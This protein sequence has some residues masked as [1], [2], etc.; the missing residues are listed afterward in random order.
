MEPWRSKALELL[1]ELTSTILDEDYVDHPMQL[2]IEITFEFDRAYEEPRNEDLIRRIYEYAFWCLEHGEQHPTDAGRDLP[3][4]V[5]IYLYEHLPTN[6][7]ARQD[8]P[9]WF[10]REEV[11]TMR[12]L[13]TYHFKE[14]DRLLALFPAQVSNRTAKREVRRANR[15]LRPW[16]KR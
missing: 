1:P 6:E 4:C 12:E 7:A 16:A 3:T 2:W 13:F 9:R 11:L 5:C 8:M 10:T 14:W 15:Q